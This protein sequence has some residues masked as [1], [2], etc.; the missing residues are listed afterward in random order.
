MC[1][2]PFVWSLET[3]ITE[4]AINGI[5]GKILMPLSAKTEGTENDK[6]LN[7]SLVYKTQK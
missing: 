3:L 4:I 5:E 7:S 6:I 2:S 1:P